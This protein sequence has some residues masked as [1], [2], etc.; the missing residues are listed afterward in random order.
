M[1]AGPT[2]AQP[3]TPN[4]TVALATLN[5]PDG[6]AVCLD[7]ILAGDALPVQ[8][9]VVDQSDDERTH[10]VV[11][12][13]ATGGVA[14]T[15]VRQR[16]L[17]LSASRNAGIE[18]AEAGI[19][20]FTDDDCV[21]DRGWL[22]AV[23]RAFAAR[24]Q[25][26]AVTGRVLPHG[27]PTPGTYVVSPR[28][29]TART[30]FSGRQ[31]PWLIGTGGNC[32]VRREWFARAGTF[33]ERLGTGSPGRAAED[34]DLFYRLLR[35][36][37]VFRYEPDAVVYHSRQTRAQRLSSRWGY[38]HGIGALCGVRVRNRDS[39]SLIVLA[40]WLRQLTFELLS[41]VIKRDGWELHQ[42][43]LGLAGTARGVVYGLSLS[44]QATGRRELVA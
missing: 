23:Q 25:L 7:A 30:D 42:R 22:A 13:R 32:A 14:L 3:T 34:A 10:A 26:A 40:V 39:Y 16:R 24:A 43:L 29:D 44:P 35:A 9:V 15:Y 38:G 18:H 17:G 37:A 2:T 8:I 4:L 21:P 36:G 5:R 27:P 41:A 6:A 12:E 33:D 11:D 19:V 20:A 28:E 31:I 1:T